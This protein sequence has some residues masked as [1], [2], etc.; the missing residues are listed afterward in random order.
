MM[1][2]LEPVGAD[3]TL[4]PREV[5]EVATVELPPNAYLHVSFEKLRIKIWEEEKRPPGGGDIG[6]TF[7]RKGE[8]MLECGY[9]REEWN[10]Y[11]REHGIP[12]EY[13]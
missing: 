4:L 9:Q 3:Y 5:V 6:W 7:V 13:R 11:C 10:R 12:R 2:I 1:V 8:E